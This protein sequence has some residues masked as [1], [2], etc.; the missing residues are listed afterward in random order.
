MSIASAA[1]ALGRE[2]EFEGKTYTLKPLTYEA[3]ARFSVWVED[4]ARLAADRGARA[5]GDRE[6]W[7]EAL[8]KLAAGGAFEP[9]GAAFGAALNTEAGNRK[10][11]A[12]MLDLPPAEAEAL[13][14][15]VNADET[16]TEW[17]EDDDGERQVTSVFRLDVLRLCRELNSDPKARAAQKRPTPATSP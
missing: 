3:L 1:L 6:P 15:R 5:E 17:A 14:W 9:G 11:I 16:P 7:R 12:L 2:F 4:R 8:V 10:T 13:S